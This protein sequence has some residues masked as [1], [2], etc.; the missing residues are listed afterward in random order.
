MATAITSGVLLLVLSWIGAV[1]VGGIRMWGRQQSMEKEIVSLH[2][3]DT[4][5]QQSID[6]LT[7][8]NEGLRTLIFAKR[9]E[10]GYIKGQADTILK[11]LK[12]SHAQNTDR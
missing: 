4:M 5:Q 8:E 2:S 9:E 11:F 12:D 10:I 1:V 6:I 3:R 7:A